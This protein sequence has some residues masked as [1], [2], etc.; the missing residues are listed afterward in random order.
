M[1]YIVFF[2]QEYNKKPSTIAKSYSVNFYS[3]RTPLQTY[4]ESCNLRHAIPFGCVVDVSRV[5]KRV[6]YSP[7]GYLVLN[8]IQFTIYGKS[9]QA[10]KRKLFFVF[11]GKFYVVIYVLYV[12]QLFQSVHHFQESFQLVGRK[13]DFVLGNHGDFRLHEF[14]FRSKN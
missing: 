4:N 3:F 12:V 1:L 6:C 2:Y 9:C 13:L 7:K 11:V 14:D 10:F 8:T 5:Q